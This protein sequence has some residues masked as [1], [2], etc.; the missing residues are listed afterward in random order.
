MSPKKKIHVDFPIDRFSR[1]YDSTS[2]KSEY[3][4]N[5]R[6]NVKAFENNY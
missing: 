4:I 3:I 1:D 2:R 6:K 5:K